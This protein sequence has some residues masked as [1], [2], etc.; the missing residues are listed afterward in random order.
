MEFEVIDLGNDI[1]R[2]AMRGRLDTPGV[3]AIETRF[4][5]S[6]VPQGRSAIV[7]LSEVTFV[8]SMGLRMFIAVARAMSRKQS[9]LVLS[10]P[11]PLVR[12]VLE[13]AALGQLI[14]IV[15]DEAEARALLAS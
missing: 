14:P 10:A 6:L 13:N 3:D 7:D 5:A 2:V 9:R 1:Q 15:Q 12:E 4:T 8:A 11:A